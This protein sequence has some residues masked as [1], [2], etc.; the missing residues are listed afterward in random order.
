MSSALH[1]VPPY[2]LARL[3]RLGF[4]TFAAYLR[5][6]EWEAVVWRY[7]HARKTHKRCAVCGDKNYQLHH[8][9]YKH[10]GGDERLHELEPLCDKHHVE[11]HRKQRASGG[12]R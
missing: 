11:E 12:R 3:R 7:Q 6:P 2:A 8:R 9:S 5:S 4:V 1:T 10:V